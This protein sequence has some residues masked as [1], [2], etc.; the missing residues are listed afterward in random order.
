MPFVSA[1]STITTNEVVIIDLAQADNDDESTVLFFVCLFL[2]Q[3]FFSFIAWFSFDFSCC[4]G[5]G[6]G[7]EVLFLCRLHFFFL[8]KGWQ[9][10][11]FE[12][13]LFFFVE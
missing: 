8:R 3:L 13:L 6:R 2:S 5:V 1:I 7:N 11:L 10:Q 4:W 12:W 9:K